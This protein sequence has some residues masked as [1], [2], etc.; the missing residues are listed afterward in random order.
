MKKRA[1]TGVSARGFTLIELLVVIAIIAILAAMLLPALAA[2]KQR[3]YLASC[4][5]N[6]RQIALGAQVYAGDYADWL[7][8]SV[9]I[10]SQTGYNTVAQE[11]YCTYIWQGAQGAGQL[12][13]STPV[14]SPTTT[15][16]NIGWIYS[17]NAAGTGG[18]F[19]CPAY[20]AKQVSSYSAGQY[21]PLLTPKSYT[22]YANIQSSYVWNPWSNPGNNSLRIYQKTTDFKQGVQVLA[23]EHLVNAN[24]TATDMT[25]NPATVAHDH[26][27]EEVVLYSDNSV[28][29]IKITPAIY[30]SAWA[31]GATLLYSGNLTN[32]LA[33]IQN[34]Y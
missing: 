7:P 23:L 26:F 19:F 31:G 28:K 8:P 4:L 14:A 9:G 30:A 5:N 34:T 24:A 3:S 12:S 25:M 32:L 33:N 13:P 1:K 27:K 18:I 16:E 22:G 17:M 10:G 15:W 29:A 6:M 20:N 21:Q 2:A 11:E